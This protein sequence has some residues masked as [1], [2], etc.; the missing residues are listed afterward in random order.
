MT[1]I[2][3]PKSFRQSKFRRY[4]C[5]LGHFMQVPSWVDFNDML[6]Q[7]PSDLSFI[8]HLLP[9]LLSL[10]SWVSPMTTVFPLLSSSSSGENSWERD[11]F[12]GKIHGRIYTDG[13]SQMDPQLCSTAEGHLFH[14]LAGFA[15]SNIWNQAERASSVAEQTTN[16]C[17][18][19]TCDQ[20][21]KLMACCDEG[22]IF[23]TPWCH[24]SSQYVWEGPQTHE[25]M[26]TCLFIPSLHICHAENLMR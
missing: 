17:Q 14:L 3:I 15:C 12:S 1:F 8:T 18:A 24:Y 16:T 20:Q 9:T 10:L 2:V 26:F 4:K 13:L 23:M 21:L 5:S 6:P 11:Q 7:F 19:W 25:D 22:N